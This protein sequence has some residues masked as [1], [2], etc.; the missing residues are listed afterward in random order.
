VAGA[1]LETDGHCPCCLK[2]VRFRS[3]SEWLRDNFL[4]S[5]CGCIPRER[6][7][8][9]TID[10]FAPGWRTG[11]THESSPGGRGASL[12]LA[13][14]CAHYD[15]SQFYPG[16]APGAQVRGHRNEDLEA[17]TFAD[18]SFDLVVTQDVMEHVFDPAAAF[19][20]IARTLK[21][22]GAHIFTTPLVN[23]AR[24]SEVAARLGPEGEVIHL[25]EAEYHGN[26]VD[27]KGSLVTMRWGYDITEHVHAACGLF[28][29]IVFIDDLSQGIRAA[30]NE[31]VVTRKPG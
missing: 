5:E 16:E 30:L 13:A 21:P 14:E 23:M 10:R 28:S 7:L 9:V 31:V 1:F 25:R 24:P 8:M 18:E 20:E 4:C 27:P 3:E 22:G 19:R 15:T 2:D 11:R 26:P 29:T 6:A 17:Q 12:R